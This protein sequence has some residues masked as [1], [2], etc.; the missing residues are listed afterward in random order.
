MPRNRYIV[1]PSDNGGTVEGLKR[2]RT[3]VVVDTRSPRT[4]GDGYA[5][6]LDT[7]RR[8]HA[9]AEAAEMNRINACINA[10]RD[11]LL[12]AVRIATDGRLA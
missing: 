6:V 3:W 4:F 7:E 12:A 11:F 9:R 8:V 5:C 2:D 1:Q 10:I